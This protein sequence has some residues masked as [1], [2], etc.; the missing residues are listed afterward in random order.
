[1]F[2]C[3]TENDKNRKSLVRQILNPCDQGLGSQ[4]LALIGPWKGSAVGPRCCWCPSE[5]IPLHTN[6]PEGDI[7]DY[8][9]RNL[10]FKVLD[11]DEAARPCKT[12]RISTANAL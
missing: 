3:S 9:K 6:G 12:R 7:R 5:A 11:L 10:R 8:V 1:V 4:H 2:R